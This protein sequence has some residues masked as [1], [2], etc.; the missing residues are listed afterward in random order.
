MFDQVAPQEYCDDDDD[1]TVN[2]DLHSLDDIVN[3]GNTNFEVHYFLTEQEAIDNNANDEIS[4]YSVTG[5]QTFYARIENINSSCHTEN[6]VDIVIIPSPVLLTPTVDFIVCDNDQDGISIINLEDK[7]PEIVV[8]TSGLNISFFDNITDL[9]ANT[10]HIPNPTTYSSNTQTIFAKIQNSSSPCYSIANINV[11][12]STQPEFPIISNFEICETDNDGKEPFLFLDKDDEILNGQ[13]GKEVLYFEDSSYTIPIDKTMVYENITSP[14]TIY[15]RV[16]NTIDTSCYGDSS[17]TIEV[18][19][20]PVYNELFTNFGVCDDISNDEKHIFNLNDKITE[21]SQG[22]STLN[23]TFHISQ[24]DAD[25]NTD[26]LPSQYTNANNP[27]TLYVRIQESLSKCFTTEELI[28]NILEAPDVSETTPFI[29]CDTD[30]DGNTTFNLTNADFQL[31]DRDQSDLVINYFENEDDIEDISKEITD[32]GN[33]INTNNPQTVY[34]KVTNTLTGCYSVRHLDLI[35]NTPPETNFIGTIQ[36]CDNI[37]KTY[38]LSQVNTMIVD[39]PDAVILTYHPSL[40]DAENNS[41]SLPNIFNYT[42]NIHNFYARVESPST[43]C[44]IYPSF[45]LQ[46]NPN[47]VPISPPNLEGCDDDYDGFL[48]F[49]LS[50]QKNTIV[51]T[52]NPTNFSVS[53]FTS[54]EDAEINENPLSNSHSAVNGE[55]VYA[56]IENNTTG[57][58]NTTSFDIIVNPLPIINIEDIVPLCNNLPLIIDADTGYSGD[59]Y[60]WS[61]GETTRAIQLQPE[62]LGGYWISITTP[63]NCVAT[64]SFSVI[65]SEEA[66]INFTTTVDF[67]DPNSITVDVSGIGNYV[68]ILDNENP[69]TSNVFE[70]VTFGLHTVTIRDINGCNDVSKEVVVIDVPKFVTPNNDGYFDTWHI[71]GIEQLPGTIVYIYNRHGKLLKTLPSNSVGWDGTFRGENMPSDDYWFVAKVK[72]DGV[73]FDVN[74]HFALKR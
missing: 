52:E 63:N 16:Q 73:D 26:P 42:S 59:T 14:Q 68:Y 69:Q 17:F 45:N 48:V 8:N 32:P 6:R 72:K 55:I 30:Y 15:V 11:I 24:N 2:V 34:I 33:Y 38:D 25:N 9:E 19:P 61:T 39:D 37:S 64:K 51:G 35:V 74:G 12:V 60:L 40:I 4:F 29:Q 54:M 10:N 22:S 46:I 28:L 70:N 7:I 20:I 66:S 3:S 50:Q 44:V 41:N 53:Y 31:L 67:A 27:Q 71:I 43:G 58:F 13:A 49:D 62:D 5:S 57:C 56:R 21:I 23:V 18:S 1:G 65:E 36:I 47:P